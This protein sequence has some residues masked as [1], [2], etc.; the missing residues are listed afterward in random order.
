MLLSPMITVSTRSET[1][2]SLRAPPRSVP[3]KRVHSSGQLKPQCRFPGIPSE[4]PRAFGRTNDD[5]MFSPFRLDVKGINDDLT[6]YD[7]WIYH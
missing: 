3:T 2:R 1:Y 6:S 7:K 4:I 5:K